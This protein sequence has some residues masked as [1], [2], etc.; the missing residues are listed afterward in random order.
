[1]SATEDIAPTKRPGNDILFAT[2]NN[3]VPARARASHLVSRVG[4]KRLRY[5]L[6]PAGGRPRRGTVVILQGRNECIEKY[7]ETIGDLSRRGLGTAIMDWRGQGGSERLIRDREK[8]HVASYGEYLADLDQFFEE[9]VLPDC[10]GPFYVLAHSMGGLIA[11]LA[12]PRLVNRVRRMVL[13]TPLLA[14]EGLPLS[15]PALHAVSRLLCGMGFGSTYLG[16]GPRAAN[17]TLFAGNKL[18]SDYVRFTRNGGIYLRHPE[19]ALGGPTA[20]WIRASCAA[21]ATVA[22]P[23]HRARI[24]VPTLIIAAGADEVVSTPVIEAFGTRLKSASV[25]TIHGARHEL[26]Q[27]ADVYREQFMAAFDAFVPGTGDD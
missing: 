9:I 20:A 22:E 25:L 8:G 13:S 27:E 2:A 26:L 6:F 21:A 16:G 19:L 3:D 12:A 10:V 24:Q 1:M 15:M 17:A 5:A 18:T 4:R 23:E 14:F 11:L 7:Y